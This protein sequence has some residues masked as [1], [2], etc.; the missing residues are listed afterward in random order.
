MSRIASYQPRKVRISITP[1]I[2][3]VFILL[4][5]FM[6]TSNFIRD[7]MVSFNLPQQSPSAGETPALDRD[8]KRKILTVF[9]DGLKLD[10]RDITPSRLTRVMRKAESPELILMPSGDTDMQRFIRVIDELA[11]IPSLSVQMVSAAKEENGR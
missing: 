3:V 8:S 11:K 5:F 9:P 1:L 10:G 4:I 7:R 6:L 2:D